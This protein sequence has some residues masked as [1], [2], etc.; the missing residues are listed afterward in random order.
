MNMLYL[1]AAPA[2]HLWLDRGDDESIRAVIQRWQQDIN[3]W[4][5]TDEAPTAD[6]L[7]FRR[8]TIMSIGFSLIAYLFV[9]ILLTIAVGVSQTLWGNQPQVGH[10]I[11]FQVIMILTSALVGL[12]ASV[13]AKA[14]I[15]QRQWR[16]VRR[17]QRGA[18]P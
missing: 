13:G 8:D 11:A 3:R 5:C 17:A 1:L 9:F 15:A 2:A 4:S 14:A 12:A 18:A 6:D 7:R 16:T 10:E